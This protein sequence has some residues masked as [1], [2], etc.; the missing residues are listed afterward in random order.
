VEG[1]EKGLLSSIQNLMESLNLSVEQAMDALKI[2]ERER[3][4]YADEVKKQG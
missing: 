2:P 3:T 1:R 4:K